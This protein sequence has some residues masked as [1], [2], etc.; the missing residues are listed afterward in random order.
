MTSIAIDDDV[1]IT[2]IRAQWSMRY[3]SGESSW[4]FLT[5]RAGGDARG[6]VL[7]AW[8]AACMGHFVAGRHNAWRLDRVLAEDRWPGENAALVDDVRLPASPPGVGAGLPPQCSP[9][10]SWRSG[11]IGRRNRG[12]TY[13]GPYAVDSADSSDVVGP[14][15]AATS[16]F[17]EAMMSNFTGIVLPGDPLFVIVSR[18][19]TLPLSPHGTYDAVSYYYPA[20]WGVVRRRLDWTW[21]T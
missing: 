14:G 5:P 21:A 10:I 6:L 20:R 11:D 3:G 12:R 18:I 16:A 8:E 15:D 13:M 9:V 1:T 4:S 2:Q 7:A 19:P 17:A